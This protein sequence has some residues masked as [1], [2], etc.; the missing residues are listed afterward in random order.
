MIAEAFKVE[1]V[2]YLSNVPGLLKDKDDESS[3][4]EEINK[5]NVEEFMQ[6]A[7]GTMKKKVMG[8]MEAIEK[9]VEEVMFADARIENPVLKAI[10]GK[11]TRIR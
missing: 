3:L 2:I 4:I 1:K 5:N 9:G 6:Y 7:Q 11:G 8:A 10:E